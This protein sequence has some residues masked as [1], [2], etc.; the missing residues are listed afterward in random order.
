MMRLWHDLHYALLASLA[1]LCA[2]VTVCAQ[3][4]ASVPEF[5]PVITDHRQLAALVL[6]QPAPEYPAVARVNYVE[7]LVQIA[8]TVNNLGNVSKAHVLKGNPV[9]ATAALK[10]VSHWVYRPL[11]TAAGPTGFSTTIRLKFS[12]HH[13][14]VQLSSQQAERDFDRQVKP[15]QIVPPAHGVHTDGL[16]RMR[17]LVNDEGQVVDTDATR[18]DTAQS[19]AVSENLRGWTFHPAHWGTLPIA[20]YLNVDVPA[21]PPTVARAAANTDRR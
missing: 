18:L 11:A 4:Y 2:A 21:G 15:P 3:N 5:P 10:A 6:T 13:P 1:I 14:G 16:V 19:K 9:L 12:I 8:I 17:L 7:G 20:S